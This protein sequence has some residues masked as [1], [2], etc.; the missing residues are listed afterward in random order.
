MSNTQKDR[1]SRMHV[2]I[3]PIKC[4]TNI[5]PHAAKVYKKNRGS[6]IEYSV[7]G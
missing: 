6:V 3:T 5:T 7:S 4:M 2:K 1:T